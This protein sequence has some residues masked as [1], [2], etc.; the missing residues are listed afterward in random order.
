VS[1][2][3]ARAPRPLGLCVALAFASALL[4]AAHASAYCRATTCNAARGDVCERDSEGCITGDTQLFWGRSCLSFSVQRDGSARNHISA[5]ELEASVRAAFDTWTSADC[6]GGT[7]PGLVVQNLGKVE[8]D[9]EEYS[10]R[11]A[12]ANIYVFRDDTWFDDPRVVDALALTTAHHDPDTGQILDVDV[13]LN[14][15][16]GNVTTS[17]PEDGADLLSILT[18]ETGHFLGLD[19]TRDTSAVMYSK[20]EPGG[21]SLRALR[22]DDVAGICAIHPPVSIA[23]SSDCRPHNGFS[24]VCAAR[25]T[26]PSGCAIAAV[27]RERAG[28]AKAL[29]A[30]FVVGAASLYRRVAREATLG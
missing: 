25:Q 13:E 5:N 18:H 24:G 8:C 27:G 21:P 26:G 14:G 16:Q 28:D 19:H 6:G 4:S 23:P 17:E 12:N 30:L 22:A 9:Q 2:K 20:Y 11:A 1:V 29:W 10:A 7:H 15:T 3:S